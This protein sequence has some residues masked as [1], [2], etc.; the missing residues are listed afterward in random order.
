MRPKK[1]HAVRGPLTQ[2]VL[3]RRGFA[4][5]DTLGDPGLCLPHFYQPSRAGR[6]HRLGLIPH[7]SDL[8]YWIENK[9]LVP[10]DV[11]IIDV[12][13][14]IETVIDAI[15]ACEATLSSSL[16]GII[17]SHA[18]GIPSAWLISFASELSENDFKFRDYFASVGLEG[19]QPLERRF[20]FDPADY[21][22]DVTLPSADL[23]AIAKRLLEVCPF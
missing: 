10:D 6:T 14:P 16:H 17:E 22:G 7:V 18:F 23:E 12:R 8:P 1:V 19:M 21:M 11:R 5:P 20:P 15:V 9:D 4:V 13:D 3:A 2:E